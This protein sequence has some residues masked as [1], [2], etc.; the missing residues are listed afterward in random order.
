MI[1]ISKKETLTSITLDI[2]D[3]NTDQGKDYIYK[4]YKKLQSGGH[5]VFPV[6]IFSELY[7]KDGNKIEDSFLLNEIKQLLKVK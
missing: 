1:K 7:D 2:Y 6:C 5:L 3:V 4:E